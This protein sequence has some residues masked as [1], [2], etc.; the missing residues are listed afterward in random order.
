MTLQQHGPLLYSLRARTFSIRDKQGLNEMYSTGPGTST[1][2]SITFD[3][4]ASPPL[5]LSLSR[6][7]SFCFSLFLSAAAGNAGTHHVQRELQV[8]VTG[9]TVQG[10]SGEEY[11][12]KFSEQAPQDV[13]IDMTVE[14]DVGES[15]KTTVVVEEGQITDVVVGS[16]WYEVTWTAPSEEPATEAVDVEQLVLGRAEDEDPVVVNLV[17]SGDPGQT[18]LFRRR[19]QQ[20]DL[21][22][23]GR[24]LGELSCEDKCQALTNQACGALGFACNIPIFQSL[25]G[26]HCGIIPITLCDLQGIADT[27]SRVCAP[28]ECRERSD[29]DE[30][31]CLHSAR[32]APAVVVVDQE[33]APHRQKIH[34]STDTR[35]PLATM[36]QT[37]LSETPPTLLR[38]FHCLLRPCRSFSFSPRRAATPAQTVNVDGIIVR[39]LRRR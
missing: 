1:T 14:D 22:F 16:D 32:T 7:L 15:V 19:T 36:E 33:N 11:V 31:P 5:S 20:A 13:A 35:T 10:P 29:P 12:V 8:D 26:H 24:E 27:C 28:S 37:F 30:S 4:A 34:H 3:R 21:D 17:Q 38:A 18:G 25:L 23:A 39:L 6:F 9:Y 2:F